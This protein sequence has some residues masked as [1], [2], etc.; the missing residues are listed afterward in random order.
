[1]PVYEFQC[2]ICGEVFEILGSINGSRSEVTC[3]RGHSQVHRLY[4]APTIIFKG[5]G[6]YVNDSRSKASKPAKQD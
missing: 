5:S 3:P 4:S 2:E 1:M 6:F